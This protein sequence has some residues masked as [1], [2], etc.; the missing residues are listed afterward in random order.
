MIKISI[1]QIADET[2]KHNIIINGN[3][4]NLKQM[5]KFCI[6]KDT[7]QESRF[8]PNISK[9]MC[10]KFKFGNTIC[11]MCDLRVEI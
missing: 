11:Q 10:S 1:I 4:I 7:N 6:V 5:L 9:E 8:T 2:T 3:K